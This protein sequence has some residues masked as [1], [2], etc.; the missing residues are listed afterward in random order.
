MSTLVTKAVKVK[1]L[2]TKLLPIAAV[3]LLVLA[4]LFMASPLLRG[5][6]AF[7]ARSGITRQFNGQTLPNGGTGT[8]APGGQNGFPGQGS[9]LQGQGD[10]TNPARQFGGQGGGLLGFGLL[11]GTTGTI[12]YAIALLVSLA[13][14]VG[15]FITRRWGQVLGI[16]MA[17][18]YLIL[19]LVNLLPTL[20]ASFL[21]TRNTSGLILGIVHLLLAI[22]VIV[23]ASIPAKK[24]LAPAIPATPPAASA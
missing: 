5:S 10:S 22:A 18:V 24:M 1:L 21:G 15:M 23:L 3:L 4:L 8:T 16:V 13:A 20:L 9:D 17:I 7:S 12:V 19:A 11:S 14:A 2:N 6:T